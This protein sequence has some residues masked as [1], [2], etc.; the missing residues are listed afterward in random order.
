MFILIYMYI[1]ESQGTELSELVDSVSYWWAECEMVRGRVS[2]M[3]QDLSDAYPLAGTIPV[4]QK[5]DETIQVS[6]YR[7]NRVYV[8]V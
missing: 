7:D 2:E 5:Q 3:T 4:I 6:K 8:H 1:V